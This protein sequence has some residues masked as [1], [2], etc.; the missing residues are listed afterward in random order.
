[1]LNIS[2]YRFSRIRRSHDQ[3][4]CIII[5]L[6]MDRRH[7]VRDE[8]RGR[9]HS[10]AGASKTADFAYSNYNGIKAARCVVIIRLN[11]AQ[12]DFVAVVTSVSACATGISLLSS[13]GDF[14]FYRRTCPRSSTYGSKTNSR[15]FNSS[16]FYKF[17]NFL[18]GNYSKLP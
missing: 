9:S 8:S 15:E 16:K 1:M 10:R 3:D 14:I 17:R 2:V 18:S 13:K 4:C 6:Q 12:Q 11:N 7:G 5:A